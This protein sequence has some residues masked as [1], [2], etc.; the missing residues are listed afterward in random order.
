MMSCSDDASHMTNECSIKIHQCRRSMRLGHISTNQQSQPQDNNPTASGGT[1]LRIHSTRFFERNESLVRRLAK[2]TDDADYYAGETFENVPS[3][4]SDAGNHDNYYGR[5]LRTRCTLLSHP[6]NR[7][8]LHTCRC[9]LIVLSQADSIYIIL[10]PT[11]PHCYN[12]M[13]T[14][15]KVEPWRL[16]QTDYAFA[17][18]HRL[19][20][21]PSVAATL[22]DATSAVV[23]VH[24]RSGQ[25]RPV[26]ST[27]ASRRLAAFSRS[28]R[29]AHCPPSW[30]TQTGQ[31]DPVT[32]W[33]KGLHEAAGEPVE[34]GPRDLS[35]AIR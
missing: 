26:H 29:F 15:F 8:K 3:P 35:F 27:L 5:R 22:V 34:T 30:L 4:L 14:D 21:T 11:N 6:D 25:T 31:F 28:I 18:G 1:N 17:C 10:L 20:H 19:M 7:S 32:M 24:G 2:L 23:N 13:D 33:S 9:V 16:G 12:S